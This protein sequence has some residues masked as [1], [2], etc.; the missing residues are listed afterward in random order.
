M[1]HIAYSPNEMF[2]ALPNYQR[3][4]FTRLEAAL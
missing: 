1:E 4:H 2:D 3:G